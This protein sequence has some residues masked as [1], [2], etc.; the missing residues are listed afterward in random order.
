MNSYWLLLENKRLL[1]C[2]KDIYNTPITYI[3]YLDLHFLFT[4]TR[5]NAVDLFTFRRLA[6]SH[7]A[8]ANKRQFVDCN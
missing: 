2:T 6:P 3:Y 8:T 7:V 5:A 4:P 1:L